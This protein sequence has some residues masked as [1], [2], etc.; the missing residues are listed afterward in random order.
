M[1][2]QFMEQQRRYHRV[3]K[4]AKVLEVSRGG[5]YAW[6]KRLPS[7]RAQDDEMLVAQIRDNQ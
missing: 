5:Y 3:E 4:M 2:Y 6:L 7:R 1:K